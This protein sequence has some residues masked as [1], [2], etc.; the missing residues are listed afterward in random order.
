MWG[1][2]PASATPTVRGSGL[3]RYRGIW[4]RRHAAVVVPCSTGSGS[5]PSGLP[6]CPSLFP[7]PSRLPWWVLTGVHVAAA[8]MGQALLLQPAPSTKRSCFGV[9]IA[10]PAF[11]QNQKSGDSPG[12]SHGVCSSFPVQWSL[13]WLLPRTLQSEVL[14]RYTRVGATM[15]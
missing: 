10:G 4:S 11:C 7:V 9:A 12:W 3:D 6:L 8:A 13:P 5:R 14:S 2:L 1:S 15:L